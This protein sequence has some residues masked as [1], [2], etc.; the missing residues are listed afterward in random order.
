MK[1]RSLHVLT[2]WQVLQYMVL[3]SP[4]SGTAEILAL[5]FR[6]VEENA[7]IKATEEVYYKYV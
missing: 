5:V 4:P 3:G 6:F 2:K 7:I 1:N